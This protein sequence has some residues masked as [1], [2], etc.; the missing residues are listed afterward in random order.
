VHCGFFLLVGGAHSPP[1]RTLHVHTKKGLKHLDG[2]YGTSLSRVAEYRAK[3]PHQRFSGIP[4][5][6]GAGLS[7]AGMSI[8][9][10]DAAAR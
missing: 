5:I 2:E 3:P 9:I 10:P 7:V 1:T 6:V 8:R 4:G